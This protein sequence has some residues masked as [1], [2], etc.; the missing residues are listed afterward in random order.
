MA[1]MT[2]EEVTERAR[3]TLLNCGD[4][5]FAALVRINN[6]EEY[7]FAMIMLNDAEERIK[8]IEKLVQTNNAQEYFIITGAWMSKVD[9]NKPMPYIRPSRDVSRQEILIISRYG[10][11]MTSDV[12]IL[13]V[14][15][16]KAPKTEDNK[17]GILTK[18]L[19]QENPDNHSSRYNV[20]LEKEGVDE[21]F[22]KT[23]RDLNEAFF[24]A[25]YDKMSEKFK[26]EWLSARIMQETNKKEG[27]RMMRKVEQKMAEHIQTLQ[28]E[29]NKQR[30]EE[31]DGDY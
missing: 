9:K 4:H 8:A 10:K 2:I 30:L 5:N 12:V 19:S 29:I 31:T 7:V 13:E 26:D 17:E 18:L 3:K 25:E 6:K 20:Y 14:H 28:S 24:K 21:N 11:D 1:K 22:E 23:T 16:D 27:D 15:R